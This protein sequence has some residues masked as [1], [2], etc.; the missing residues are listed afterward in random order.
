MRLDEGQTSPGTTGPGCDRSLVDE[1]CLM[2]FDR[3]CERRNVIALGYLMH[4]WPL[5]EDSES[6]T[7]QLLRSLS[8]LREYHPGALFSE[9][10]AL[11]NL[12]LTEE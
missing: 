12:V 1:V 6:L 8:E 2:L 9:E 10:R 3:W 4:R 11:L 5:P 7:G